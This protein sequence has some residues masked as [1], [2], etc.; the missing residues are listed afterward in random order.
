MK[1]R[2][3]SGLI[4]AL[5]FIPILIIG[6]SF[7]AVMCGILSILALKE[8]ID[9]KES[10]QEFPDI[11]K[12][13]S[14]IL[15]V[16]L[17]FSNFESYN[18]ALGISYK[19]LSIVFISLFIPCLFIKKDKYLS[20][21]AF[22]LSS[23][24]IFIG[25]VFNIL[26][27]IRNYSLSY[28]IYIILI[29]IATDIFAYFIGSLIGKHKITKISP[30]KTW[31]GSIGGTIMGVFIASTYYAYVIGNSYSFKLIL[32]TFILSVIAQIGDLCFSKIKRENNI[33]DYSELIPGHGGI[34][35]R[36]DSL[37]FVSLAFTILIRYI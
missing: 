4:M 31:E 10:H 2:I 7:F 24:T 14:F 33:K 11:V 19:L 22:Y 23:I 26:I 8:L 34:L 17:T 20:K 18:L 25:L 36:I 30:N 9:L 29:T 28:F 27:L 12:L 15:V 21:D 5:I 37:I 3:I 1:K 6:K 35:D 32:I 13:I 16:F